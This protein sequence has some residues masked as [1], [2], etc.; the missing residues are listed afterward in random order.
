MRDYTRFVIVT[1]GR[2]GSTW[3]VQAL[4][5]H[6]EVVCFGSPFEVGSDY[7]SFDV[8]GYDNHDS[9]ARALRDSDGVAFLTSYIYGDHDASKQAIGFKFQYQNW[10]GFGKVLE[11]LT[12]DPAIKVIHLRRENLL[13]LL[14][15]L[16][17][18]KATGQYHRRPRQLGWRKALL[19]IRH[20]ARAA[21]RLP[22]L[23]T[24]KRYVAPV[25]TLSK[26]E[27]SEYFMRIKIQERRFDELFQGHERLDITYEAMVEDF[28]AISERMLD[29][30]GVHTEQL[31][32]SQQ[33]LNVQPVRALLS[34]FDELA[35]VF[36][37][38]PAAT[39]FD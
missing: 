3:L 26:E 17:L 36:R 16:R 4:N 12:G 7:V 11:A 37:D 23:L 13:R 8:D 9:Q 39:Y 15:S 25:L 32:Y 30:T 35:D 27:C 21:Q 38:T 2:S 34:N 33:Q 24:R 1:T 31:S 22:S 5:S 19:A 14:I 18:A 10:V 6:S 28:P 29:F 20:P